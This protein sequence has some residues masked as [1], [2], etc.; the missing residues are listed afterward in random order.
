[1]L[2]A[3]RHRLRRAGAAPALLRR[4]CAAAARAL[5]PDPDSRPPRPHHPPKAKSVIFLF[6][7]G[8]PSHIDTFDPKP[9]LNKLAGQPLPVVVQ[10]GDPGDGREEPAA[11]GQPAEVDAAR[12]RRPV[13][14]RLAAAHG[15]PVPTTCASIRSLLGRRPQPLGRRLPDEH[16]LDP[17]RPAV[18][19]R[20][21][22]LRPGHREREPAGVR[23]DGGQR[24]A[25]SINGPRNWGAGLHARR[26]PGHAAGSRRRADPAPGQ[27]Q[28]RD[29]RAAAGQARPARPS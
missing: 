17:R 4:D 9:E 27:S 25:R 22:Q 24:R 15:R 14:Q 16:R 21:G 1:M 20:V 13:G 19:R 11:H 23:R 5:N 18:A 2:R 29:R 28:G 26:L 6:M 7:E 8:G 12:R 10:A 3:C